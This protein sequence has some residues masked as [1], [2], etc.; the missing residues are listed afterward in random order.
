VVRSCSLSYSLDVA[1]SRVMSWIPYLG[2]L[3]THALLYLSG[4]LIFIDLIEEFGSLTQCIHDPPFWL[5]HR[6]CFDH[7]SW[8]TLLLCSASIDVVRSTPLLQLSYTGSLRTS[9]IL[10]SFGSLSAF[11]MIRSC[12]SLIRFVQPRSSW[13]ALERCSGSLVMA[14][15]FSMFSLIQDGYSPTTLS[16]FIGQFGGAI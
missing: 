7:S 9:V 14:H 2:S 5:A 13:L 4:S 16:L 1:H 6:A 12:G 8:L 10:I 15:S 3:M 11:V